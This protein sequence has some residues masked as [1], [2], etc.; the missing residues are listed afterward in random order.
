MVTKEEIDEIVITYPDKI[1]C[2]PKSNFEE[3]LGKHLCDYF[4]IKWKP[5]IRKSNLLEGRTN[6]K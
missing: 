6:T 5:I 1:H 4:K 2:L 3:Q